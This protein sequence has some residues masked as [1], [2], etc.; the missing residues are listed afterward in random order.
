MG[1]IVHNVKKCRNRIDSLTSG[2]Q[3]VSGIVM[4][5]V[6]I[7]SCGASTLIKRGGGSVLSILLLIRLTTCNPNLSAA[8]CLA[9]Y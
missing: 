6:L 9:G 2:S 3:L 7:F 1:V 8:N 5:V 4:V